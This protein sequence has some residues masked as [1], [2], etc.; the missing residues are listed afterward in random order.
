MKWDYSSII[1]WR[2]YISTTKVFPFI[3]PLKQPF[4]VPSIFVT[5]SHRSLDSFL[6]DI[7]QQVKYSVQNQI[8]FSFF[9]EWLF[10]VSASMS[11]PGDRGIVNI[12]H[13]NW[14]DTNSKQSVTTTH[15]LTKMLCLKRR[16][17]IET[18]TQN[19]SIF[20]THYW[21]QLFG[22]CLP[23]WRHPDVNTYVSCRITL[24]WLGLVHKNKPYQLHK[25]RVA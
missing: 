16:S 19:I 3:C 18:H 13:L 11:K 6:F 20:L 17:L 12:Y 5:L 2:W 25:V 23:S 9:L 10:Q 14:Y 15:P 8:W 7:Y 24:P 4:F 21:C 1:F 22:Q